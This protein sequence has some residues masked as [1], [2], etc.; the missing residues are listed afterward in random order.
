MKNIYEA[1]YQLILAVKKEPRT[2]VKSKLLKEF[3]YPQELRRFLRL[4][5]NVDNVFGITS[6]SFK[7]IRGKSGALREVDYTILEKLLTIDGWNDKFNFLYEQLMWHSAEAKEIYLNAIDKDLKIGIGVKT[8]NKALPGCIDE[9]NIMLAQKQTEERFSKTFSD[10]EWVY[11]NQKIDGVRCIVEFHGKNDIRFFSRNGIKMEEFLVENI[12]YE[13][14]KHYHIFKGR[15]LDGEIYSTKFQRFMRIYRRKNIDLDSLYIRHSTKLAI[16]DLIDMCNEPLSKRV[17]EMKRL[18]EAVDM[19]FI[20]FLPYYKTK[21]NH[22]FLLQVARKYIQAEAEGIIVKH[23]NMPYE[24]KRSDFWQKFKNKETMDLLLIGVFEGEAGTA[25]EGTL[26]GF[27]LDYNGTPVRCGSGFSR[28][29]RDY[30]W[31]VRDTLI[32]EVVEVSYMEKTDTGSL[33]H[34]IFEKFR[35]DIV[36]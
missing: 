32:G 5:Y 21:T 29:E 18:S 16:F 12:R 14:N 19:R 13:L 20:T 33:R 31:K 10:T 3:P 23:P 25:L 27:I 2:S 1:L 9:F 4:V 7:S 15:R 22:L 28:R 35:F 8:I 11:F 36:K 24:F 17:A 6:Q 34:P 26:G 30:L